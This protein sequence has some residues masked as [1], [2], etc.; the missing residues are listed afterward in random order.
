MDAPRFVYPLVCQWTLAFFHFR[1]IVNGA[2]VD[3]GALCAQAPVS[4][5]AGVYL[6]VELLGCVAILRLA[7]GETARLFH[8]GCTI[9]HTCR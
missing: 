4:V 7:F 2:A 5:L 8:G 3:L 9:L 6:G 1:A